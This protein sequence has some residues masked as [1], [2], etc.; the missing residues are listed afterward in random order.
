MNNTASEDEP[1]DALDLMIPNVRKR[2][3]TLYKI[4]EELAK[5]SDR[6]C[7][8]VAAAYLENELTELLSC[9]FVKQGKSATDALFDF[10][11]PVGTFS[12]KI[13]LSYALGLLPNEINNALNIVRKIRNEFAHLQ[14]PLNF[15]SS[16]VKQRVLEILPEV[17]SASTNIRE[18]FILKM[19]AVVASIHLIIAGTLHRTIPMYVA[20]PIQESKEEHD[21]DI[22]ARHMMNITCPEITYEQAIDLAKQFSQMK[23]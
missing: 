20:L 3:A 2:S 8:L 19:Q 9:F 17:G 4:P 1:F 11:G 13:K 22:A 21:L 18:K 12:A 10:N 6:G 16:V 23:Y 5:E 7:A 14:E 15:D